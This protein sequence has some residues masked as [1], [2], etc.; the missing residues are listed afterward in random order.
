MHGASR[1]RGCIPLFCTVTRLTLSL[2]RSCLQELAQ[3][4]DLF[5]LMDGQGV[6]DE[7]QSAFYAASVTL[8]LQHVHTSTAHESLRADAEGSDHDALYLRLEKAHELVLQLHRVPT[9]SARRSTMLRTDAHVSAQVW[10]DLA[11]Q[12]PFLG[13]FLALLRALFRGWRGFSAARR[14]GPG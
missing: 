12:W 9:S 8:A 6:F 10:N 5:S 13:F 7:P 14:V 11:W 3:G 4:G 2:V 1:A